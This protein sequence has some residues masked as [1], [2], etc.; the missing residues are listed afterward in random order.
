MAVRSKT[1]VGDVGSAVLAEVTSQFNRAAGYVHSP[2]GQTFA[3]ATYNFV[4]CR[5]TEDVYI[6]SVEFGFGS[7]GGSFSHTLDAV[8][9]LSGTDP[10]GTGGT[11]ICDADDFGTFVANNFATSDVWATLAAMQAVSL[12]STG[13]DAPFALTAG[14]ALGLRIVATAGSGVV[15]APA[16]LEC[17]SVAYRPVKDALTLSPQY[18]R[19]MQN[20]TATN[21]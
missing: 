20:W 10:D 13:S 2:I 17:I 15:T 5:F 11:L 9:L 18:T 19:T 8:S 4:L 16:I 7:A 12:N 1:L 6:T 3:A 14:N 21:R